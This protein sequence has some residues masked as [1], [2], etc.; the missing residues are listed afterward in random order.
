MTDTRTTAK[1]I[2]TTFVAG[3][4]LG[5]GISFASHF[6]TTSCG[7]I[8]MSSTTVPTAS[9]QLE[10]GTVARSGSSYRTALNRGRDVWNNNSIISLPSGTFLKR[11]YAN[12][13]NNGW[14]GLASVNLNSSCIVTNAWSRLNDFY[15]RN[16]SRYSQTSLDHV[17]CQE[18]GH[19]FGLDHNRSSSTTCMN[20]T[21]LT[22]G[23]RINNHDRDALNAIY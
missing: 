1:K 22:A 3:A 13:G 14:L 8:R 2:A 15:L 19:V 18:I 9:A 6:W 11:Y 21:I 12:Y 17:A 4:V 7:Q 16:T 10:G 23:A 5:A 20:D